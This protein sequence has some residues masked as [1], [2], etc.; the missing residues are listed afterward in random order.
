MRPATKTTISLRAIRILPTTCLAI[1]LGAATATANDELY[2][3]ADAAAAE[4]RLVEM[5]RIYEDILAT[6]PQSVRALTGKAAALAWQ[7]QFTDAQATYAQALALEPNNVDARIG[8]AY[9][10]AWNAQY[11]KAHTEF[12]RALDIDPTNAGAR[13]GVGLAYLWAGD[14]ELAIDSL[15]VAASIAP[16][17]PEVWEVTGHAHLQQH[18]NRTAISFYDRALSLEPDRGSA[19]AARA[20]A[21]RAA[22]ALELSVQAGSTS[23]ADSGLRRV[24]VAHWPSRSTRLALRYDNTLGLDSASIANRNEDADG[25][26]ANVSH[27]FERGF[28]LALEGGS[29]DLS[30]GSLTVGTLQGILDTSF[31]SVRLG[32]QVGDHDIGYTD[33][34]AFAGVNFPVGA[35]WRIEPIVYVAE[36]GL[37]ADSEWRAVVNAEKRISDNFSAGGFVGT[38]QVDAA[39]AEFDGDTAVAGAWLRWETGGPYALML[40]GRYEDSPTRDFSVIEIGFTY[41]LPGDQGGAR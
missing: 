15:D 20:E 4:G 18:N 34:L 17:D 6:D 30:D 14:H 22:P 38:G 39:R 16:D 32:A 11:S 1:L 10:Y 19:W 9:A 23:D 33:K 7:E 29:R 40:S 26:F 31:G 36:T 2:A 8:L 21:F 24:E 25:Y 12:N 13:K 41:R 5:Q 3:A 35:T 37:D 27:R 28:T